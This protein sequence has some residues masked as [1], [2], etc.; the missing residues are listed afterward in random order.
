MTEDF[1]G[2]ACSWWEGTRLASGTRE[3]RTAWNLGE[4]ADVDAGYE[5]TVERIDQ[6]DEGSLELVMTLLRSAPDDFGVVLVGAGPLED[7]VKEHG[8]GLSLQIEQLARQCPLF[9]RALSSV[10]MSSGTLSPEAEGRLAPWIPTL[11]ADRD[12]RS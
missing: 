5:A 9:T 11:R 7:L 4:P 3:E 10:W 2:L 12:R 1:E 6:G 8:N